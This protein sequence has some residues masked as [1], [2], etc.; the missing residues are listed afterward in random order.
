M[1]G[2]IIGLDLGKGWSGVLAV[3]TSGNSCVPLTRA[4]GTF[5]VSAP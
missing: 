2:A 3:A 5:N 1:H 4:D